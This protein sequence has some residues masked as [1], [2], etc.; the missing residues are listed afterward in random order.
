[1]DK[2]KT[3]SSRKPV[4]LVL[5][6]FVNSLSLVREL[7]SGGMPVWLLHFENN[8]ASKSR[9]VSRSFIHDFRT[10]DE[11]FIDAL[12]E[13]GKMLVDRGVLFP[14]HDYHVRMM[15]GHFETLNR[16]YHVAV[17]PATALNLI[18][19]RWQ[20]NLCDRIGI[21]YP[22]TVFCETPEE[23]SC[24]IE[25]AEN[26]QFPLL[27]K[28]IGRAKNP[29]ALAGAAFRAIQVDKLQALRSLYGPASHLDQGG[30]LASEIIP[31]GPHN[32]WA[33]TAYSG[34]PG[35]IMAGWTG[36]KLTQRPHDFGDFSTAETTL[37]DVVEDQGR[38]LLEG[39]KHQGIGEPEFK[40]D[41]RDGLYKLTE[42]NPRA[43]MWHIA[44]TFAGVNLALIQY[45]HLI[46]DSSNCERLCVRQESKPRRLVFMSHEVM[47]MIDHYPRWPFIKS[48]ARSLFLR[49][50][51]FAI[52]WLEDPKP[53][54]HHCPASFLRILRIVWTKLWGRFWEVRKRI[55]FGYSSVN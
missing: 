48:V 39:C 35:Q 9:Y 38:R 37:N 43:M 3:S 16:N 10:N 17:N 45:Y 44:G 41:L 50:K 4:A 23:A 51:R 5:G 36:R 47:N 14:T 24:F 52:W 31:G 28:P 32:I 34:R 33:Y 46:G 55:G 21:P 11:A 26:L 53:W 7:A 6:G 22:K 49:H 20:Y 15:A 27:L 2:R 42:I 13:I 1:M 40:Y 19:K 54:L 29:T 30:F 25:R 12:S 18:S 8:I